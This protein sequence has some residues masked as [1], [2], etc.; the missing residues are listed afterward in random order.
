MKQNLTLMLRLLGTVLLLF[1]MSNSVTAQP[2]QQGNEVAEREM[3]YR[4]AHPYGIWHR[5]DQ[6]DKNKK[7]PISSKKFKS[8]VAYGQETD[9]PVTIYGVLTFK[10]DWVWNGKEE[11]GVYTFDTS[12]DCMANPVYVDEA[13]EATGGGTYYDKTLYF[14]KVEYD[15]EGEN[16]YNTRLLSYDTDTWK[17]LSSMLV[18]DATYMASDMTYD[19]VSGM[20]YG[21]FS[22]A[23]ASDFDFSMLDPVTKEL[24]LINNEDFRGENRLACLACNNQGEL[25]G[26][27]MKGDLYQIDKETGEKTLIGPTD[28]VPSNYL[29][30]ATFDPNTGKLYWAAVDVDEYSYLCELDLETGTATVL[31]EFMDG[32]QFSTLYIPEQPKSADVPAEAQDFTVNFEAD[33]LS[34]N[35]SF[36]IPEKSYVGNALAGNVDYLVELNDKEAGKGTAAPGETVKVDLAAVA[37]LNKFD[38][39]LSNSEGEGPLSRIRKWIGPDYPKAVTDLN[40]SIKD[41][42]ATLTWTAPTEGTNE[43]YVNPDELKYNIVRNPGNV[44]VAEN[45]KGN[46]FT[47]SIPEAD[48]TGYIYTVIPS[49]KGLT[50]EQATSDLVFF[51]NS[52]SVP[53]TEDFSDTSHF[54]YFTTYDNNEDDWTWTRIEEESGNQMRFIYTRAGDDW[55][56]SPA[57]ALKG[58]RNYKLSVNIERLNRKCKPYLEGNLDIYFGTGDD[59]TK[60]Q[61]IQMDSISVDTE[62]WITLLQGAITPSGEGDYHIAFYAGGPEDA[63][64]LGLTEFGIVENHMLAAPAEVENLNVTAGEKGALKS[65]ITFNAPLLT[66]EGKSLAS[67]EGI[68]IYRDDKLVKTLSA[69]PG[70]DISYVDEDGVSAGFHTYKIVPRNDK[71]EGTEAYSTLYIGTDIAVAP[72]NVKARAELNDMTLTWDAPEEG[73]NGG[74]LDTEAL[75]YNII[76][77]EGEEMATGVKGCTYTFTVDQSGIQRAAQYG[78]IP[79]SAGGVGQ[80][81]VSN[82]IILGEAYALPFQE[83]FTGGFATYNMWWT[84]SDSNADYETY[85]IDEI[86]SDGDG[87]CTMTDIWEAAEVMVNT[88]KISLEG[89][90]N[91]ELMFHYYTDNALTLN[92]EAETDA[93]D[94]VALKTISTTASTEFSGEIVSLEH[95][96]NASYVVIRF[97]ATDIPEYTSLAL[98]DISVKESTV[99]GISS[100]NTEDRQDTDVYTIDGK[101][102][103]NGSSLTRGL[104]IIKKGNSVNKVI[105]K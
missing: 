2:Q 87:Y 101:K 59:Y 31:G 76:N 77:A 71:G 73:V 90:S 43:G 14:T 65:A 92:V 99:T 10:W 86:S 67:I 24:T 40:V 15:F 4:K 5:I 42:V 52:F 55:L 30:S 23:D 53:Y 12:G 38:V 39:V 85:I 94:I 100:I 82:V 32:E 61:K 89:A 60:Y 98:D 104:Y 19:P 50:G 95:V 22:T 1:I 74:Y 7:K 70:E 75:T 57:I 18:K 28:I 83:N 48:F 35:V 72:T 96:K 37:G 33:S 8:S 93:G 16:F 34:G 25:Y 66:I 6:L 11:Y 79:V 3:A 56:V 13:L 17:Q 36:T 102:L 21:C 103:T 68:D 58:D 41:F 81:G 46:T 63:F 29:Q 84:L 69:Q 97:H 88:G 47:D 26:V 54:E 45:H 20:I 9:S 91:P 49:Y 105:V 27:D 44:T 62:T 51:G 78:V 80:N 64:Y